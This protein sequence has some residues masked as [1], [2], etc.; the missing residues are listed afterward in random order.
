M[1]NNVSNVVNIGKPNHK[2]TIWGWFLQPNFGDIGYGL[3]LAEVACKPQPVAW[4]NQDQPT[5][6]Q[7][8]HVECYRSNAWV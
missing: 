1:R 3:S 6:A 5:Q 8:A 7:P 2:P 4:A